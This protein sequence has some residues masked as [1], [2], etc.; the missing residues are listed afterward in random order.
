MTRLTTSILVVSLLA[1]CG[2]QTPVAAQEKPES[3]RRANPADPPAGAA[4]PPELVF[5]AGDRIGM[6]QEQREAFFDRVEKTRSRSEELRVK[7]ERETAALAPLTDESAI[8]AQLDKVRACVDELKQLHIGFGVAVKNLLT[9][10]QQAKLIEISK[11]VGKGSDGFHQ[12]EEAAGK[13]IAEKNERVKAGLQKWVENG[14]DPSAIRK[15]MEETVGPLFKADRPMEVEGALDRVLKQLNSSPNAKPTTPATEGAATV[16]DPEAMRKRL[17]D[18]VALVQAG[19]QTWQA[20]GRDFSAIAQV[21]EQEF[22]PLLEA[23]KA[24][25][26]EAELDRVL[27]LLKQEAASTAR[28]QDGEARKDQPRSPGNPYPIAFHPVAQEELKLSDDQ[29]QKILAKLPDY[30]VDGRFTAEKT[31]APGV[32]EKLWAFLKETLNAEQFKRFQQL[33]LQHDWTAVI[34]PEIVKALEITDEERN[35]IMGVIQGLKKQHQSGGNPPETRVKGV[36]VKARVDY[37]E[38]VEAILSDAQKTQWKEMRGKLF[39]IP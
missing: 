17:T 4:F 27:E 6:T 26:A 32:R 2:R 8:V 10:E 5:L 34:R 29:K 20:S 30:Q 12:L 24:I 36:R 31:Q 16:T 13:R 11:G 33:E 38:K 7:L 25:E 9:P 15:T 23:G 3:V 35:Q 21:M 39:D 18:K 28:A 19:V 1:M 22:K 14:R 37:D